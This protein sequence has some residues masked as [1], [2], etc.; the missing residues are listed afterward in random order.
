[1]FC[2]KFIIISHAQ[3]CTHLVGI[4]LNPKRNMQKI[5]ALKYVRV[6]PKNIMA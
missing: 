5:L 3:H 6:D 1:M 4:R 2:G